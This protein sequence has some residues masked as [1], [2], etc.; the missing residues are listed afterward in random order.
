MKILTQT[1]EKLVLCHRQPSRWLIA[2]GYI[3]VALGLIVGASFTSKVV[4][5][6]GKQAPSCTLSYQSFT[7]LSL[8]RDIQLKTA[9]SSQPCGTDNRTR[10]YRCGRFIVIL[11][12]DIGDLSFPDG[13][14]PEARDRAN[15]F[16]KNPSA[17][18]FQIQS[19]ALPILEDHSFFAFLGMV[20]VVLLLG[21]ASK[22][23]SD[24]EVYIVR[25]NRDKDWGTVVRKQISGKPAIAVTEFP[26]SAIQ[27]VDLGPSHL[28]LEL[29]SGRE[30][31]IATAIWGKKTVVEPIGESPAEVNQAFSEAQQVIVAFLQI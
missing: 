8:E 19:S 21:R 15:Q 22:T 16:I 10:K 14:S 12:T 2:A 27:S 5:P 3:L 23:L 11:S 28:V 1:Y 31:R 30:V 7:G 25:F 26:L 9:R 29:K 17:T 18:S 20:F 6:G 24:E 4:C 13:Y